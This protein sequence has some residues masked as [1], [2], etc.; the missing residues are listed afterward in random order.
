MWD[1]LICIITFSRG[2]QNTHSRKLTQQ[3]N[4]KQQHTTNYKLNNEVQQA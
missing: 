4:T 2:S 1:T 3:H